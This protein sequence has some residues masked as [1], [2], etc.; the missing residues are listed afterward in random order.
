L[1]SRTGLTVQIK[2]QDRVRVIPHLGRWIRRHDDRMRYVEV[3]K[4]SKWWTQKPHQCYCV[5]PSIVRQLVG[6]H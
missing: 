1:V 2:A 3:L 6:Q 5:R 4:R